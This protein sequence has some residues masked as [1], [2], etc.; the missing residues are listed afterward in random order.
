MVESRNLDVVVLS[1]EF[2][3]RHVHH[4][5]LIT[6]T[7]VVAALLVNHL[8]GEHQDGGIVGLFALFGLI[9]PQGSD[10]HEQRVGT[11]F[12]Y[13]VAGRTVD[14]LQYCLRLGIR[15]VCMELVIADIVAHQFADGFC[16]A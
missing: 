5:I 8:H 4:D 15:E 10:G 14:V 16:K 7:N 11:R 12:L 3:E 9:P 6:R 13:G 2:H 1:E